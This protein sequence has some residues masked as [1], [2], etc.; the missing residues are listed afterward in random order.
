MINSGTCFRAPEEVLDQ[1]RDEHGVSWARDLDPYFVEAEEFLRVTPLDP[2]RMGRNGQ[3]ALEG[4]AAIG[5]IGWA[6]LPQRRQLRAVQLLPVRM[7]DRRQ[8]GHAR[9]LPP[10]RG[11]RR[12]EDQGRG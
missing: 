10:P 6:D 12:S 7:R 9:Q 5:G 2:E 3:L 4:A 8:A 1:W 11:R